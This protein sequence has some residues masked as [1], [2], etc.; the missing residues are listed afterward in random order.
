MCVFKSFGESAV[1]YITKQWFIGTMCLTV[2]GT[3]KSIKGKKA[4]VRLDSG[5]EKEFMSPIPV[6]VGQRV[7]TFQNVIVS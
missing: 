1:N 6:K 3:V 7:N 4:I 2:A 5:L